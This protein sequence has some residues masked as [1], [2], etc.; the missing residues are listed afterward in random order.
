[1]KYNIVENPHDQGHDHKGF[2]DYFLNKLSTSTVTE[3]PFSHL[4]IDNILPDKF[5]HVCAEEFENLNFNEFRIQNFL[6]GGKYRDALFIDNLEDYNYHKLSDNLKKFVTFF[7][8]NKKYI[9]R[10]FQNKL[11]T[12]RYTDNWNLEFSLNKDSQKYF[13]EPHPDDKK[14]IFTILIYF[15]SNNENSIHGTEFYIKEEGECDNCDI[16]HFG[17]NCKFNVANKYEFKKNKI[18]AFSPSLNSWHGVRKISEEICGT[19]NSFQIF[20]MSND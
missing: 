10:S 17:E 7:M 19:R 14:N 3:R 4:K 15:P 5:Y 9:Y 8:D 11:V 20:F 12:S 16:E 6:N 18:I 2:G 13:I 1:M